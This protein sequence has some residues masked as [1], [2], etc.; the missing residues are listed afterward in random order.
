MF[1]DKI[2]VQAIGTLKISD[3]ETGT[4]LV[5]KRNAIH[6]EIWRMSWLLHLVVN[7]VSIVQAMPH[8]SIGWRLVMVEV[9]QQLHYHTALK[10][11]H[12]I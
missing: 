11:F 3:K 8:I 12:Y 6:P 2:N 4:V 7:Q 1:K 5:D 10:S 9:V